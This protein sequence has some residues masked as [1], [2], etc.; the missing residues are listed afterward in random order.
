M[1]TGLVYLFGIEQVRRGL[2]QLQQFTPTRAEHQPPVS[3]IIPC[4]D[5]ARHL[6][7]LLED[8]NRQDYPKELLQVL[9]ID[10]RSNDGTAELARCFQGRI[11]NL[12]VISLTSCPDHVSPKKN[13]IR[14]GWQ[15]AT[16]E[17]V[18]TTD[19]DC[20]VAP[21]W[22]SG[23]IGGFSA[24][25]GVVTGL[26]IFD[27]AG[28]EPFWQRLQQLDYLSHS[29][30]AAG[31]IARGY[32]FNCNGSNLAIRREA[33]ADAGGF[34]Q[35]QQV[36]TGDDTL[37]LQ[38]IRQGGRWR[39]RFSADPDTLVRSWPEEKPIQVLNQRLRWGSGGLSYTPLALTFALLTFLFFLSLFLTP[40]FWLAGLSTGAGMILFGFKFLQEGRVMAQGWRTFALQ[41]DWLTFSVLE[42]I[43]IPAILTF[44][45][46]GHFWGFRWK[47][48]RFKRTGKTAAQTP[49][50]APS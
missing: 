40:F 8:I 23:L 33:F 45:I 44:S 49:E 6:G 31:A 24:E 11:P 15:T 18:I 4:R 20:R 42:L 9:V 48:E 43:H 12:E 22:I 28:P 26:T 47:G 32:A 13:A 3:V 19:G 21:G 39:I 1:S 25:T 36:I 34:D 16:G 30:F 37:L 5:E 7:T 29:F 2:K 46:G 38:H 50:A 14:R 17:I 27:R 35:F 10:D 41:P